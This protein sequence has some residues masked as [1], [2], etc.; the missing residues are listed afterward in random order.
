MLK[1]LQNPDFDN[2]GHRISV[3]FVDQFANDTIGLAL[4]VAS[5]ES[6]RHRAILPG[7]GYADVGFDSELRDL[8]REVPAELWSWW[9]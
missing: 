9:T 5:M 8:I 7:W 1:T 2:D 3:N 4:T 6:P